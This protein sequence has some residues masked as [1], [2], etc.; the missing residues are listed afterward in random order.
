MGIMTPTIVIVNTDFNDLRKKDKT[1]VK[2][3]LEKIL[4][5]S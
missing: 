1:T 5:G 3:K 2:M 4:K